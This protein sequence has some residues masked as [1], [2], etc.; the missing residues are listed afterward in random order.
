MLPPP[1]GETISLHTLLKLKEKGKDVDSTSDCVHNSL[2]GEMV[3]DPCE[4]N[5]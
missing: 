1:H 3:S 4:L 2:W 5:T